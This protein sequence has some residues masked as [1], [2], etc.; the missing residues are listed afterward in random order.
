M[1]AE[2]A[3]AA[4]PALGVITDACVVVPMHNE[5]TVI[6]AVVRD[7]LGRFGTVVCVDDGSADGS[8]AAAR[9]AGAEVVRHAINLGQGAALQTGFRHA[10]A[11]TDAAWFVTFDADGQHDVADAVHM[12]GTARSDDLDVVLGSR[13]LGAALD[14][15]R[16]R[17]TLLRAAVTFTRLSTGLRVTDTHNGLRVLSRTAAQDL[18]I[19]LRGMAHASEILHHVADR[20][21]RYAEVPVR[22]AYTEYSRAKGQSGL[23]A[24][25]V[26]CDLFLQR[27]EP[28]R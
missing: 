1:V 6:A 21:L 28:S 10:L 12:V 3:T 16:G 17:R 20:G 11:G 4:E 19:R 25:N 26:L 5:A 18:E 15:P 22:I 2:C 24:V 27:L 23:N 13:F 9:A 8:A 7:L 14:M